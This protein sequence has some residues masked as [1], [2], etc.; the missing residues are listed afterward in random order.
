VRMADNLSPSSAD[1]TE[2]GSLNIPA[3]S[4]SHRAVVG[5]LYVRMRGPSVKK[6]LRVFG[7]GVLREI[8]GLGG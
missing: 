1:V 3:P 5:L 2:S 7:C 6:R 4:G 8:L